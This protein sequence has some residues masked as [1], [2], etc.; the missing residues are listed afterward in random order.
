MGPP[1]DPSNRFLFDAD[2]D[3]PLEA[4]GEESQVR[5]EV[6]LQRR[7]RGAG[8][9]LK[10]RRGRG[11]GFTND[12]ENSFQTQNNSSYFENSSLSINSGY[13]HNYH[14]KNSFNQVDEPN[15]ASTPQNNNSGLRHSN[16]K[17]NSMSDALRRTPHQDG[18]GDF[19]LSP[20]LK[21]PS[22]TSQ[23]IA[24]SSPINSM[25][26]AEMRITPGTTPISSRFASYDIRLD[27]E[28]LFT[29]SPNLCQ[30]EYRND[31]ATFNNNPG[32]AGASDL[33][34]Q[35]HNTSYGSN[36]NR[37]AYS[38]Y[39]DNWRGSNNPYAAKEEGSAVEAH[40][41]GG[42][43]SNRGRHHRGHDTSRGTQHSTIGGGYNGRA[44]ASGSSGEITGE[45]GC[46]DN[47][48]GNHNRGNRRGRG[49]RNNPKRGGRQLTVRYIL[50]SSFRVQQTVLNSF[51]TYSWLRM[52][53]LK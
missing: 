14:M 27:D 4:R 41:Y 1:A 5:S 49:T 35:L 33:R 45:V 44:Y 37:S 39:S 17:A 18:G 16:F 30:R 50:C 23:Q 31:S 11:R 28:Q 22:P 21:N 34:H 3:G 25:V 38:K 48:R 46:Y 2:R 51:L 32:V 24:H 52:L 6:G 19:T 12:F 42:R 13:E 10:K 8:G 20:I 36:S 29:Q 9:N 53:C 15:G 26:T 47:N 40:F 7:G 43:G